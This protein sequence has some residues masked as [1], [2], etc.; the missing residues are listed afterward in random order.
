M[1]TLTIHACVYVCLLHAGFWNVIWEPRGVCTPW[2]L[3]TCVH[4]QTLVFCRLSVSM[5]GPTTEAKRFACS[6]YHDHACMLLLQTQMWTAG[7]S[8]DQI[9]QVSHWRSVNR[10]SLCVWMRLL[11]LTRSFRAP[12]QPAHLPSVS[13]PS[14]PI[15]NSVFLCASGSF[16][17]FLLTVTYLPT[18]LLTLVHLQPAHTSLPLSSTIC[19]DRPFIFSIYFNAG[20]PTT[21]TLLFYKVGLHLSGG[22]LSEAPLVIP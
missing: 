5:T 2:R 13:S 6:C 3:Q 10:H 14:N 12:A 22:V 21:Q 9:A 17:I 20:I 18:C 8:T 16:L 11:F 1:W 19:Y 15:S 7:L 4:K